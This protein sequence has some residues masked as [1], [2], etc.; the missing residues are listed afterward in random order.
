ME[1]KEPVFKVIIKPNSSTN[2]VIGFDKEKNAYIIKIRAKP[3]N[4]KANVELVKF[5]SKVLGKK[6]KI[7]SGLRSREK[8]ISI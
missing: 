3:E 1:I 8:V 2:E 7:K 5:L 6:V 4:N